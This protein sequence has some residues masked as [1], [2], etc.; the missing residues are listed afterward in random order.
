MILYLDTSALVK[1]YIK[2]AFSD[3]VGKAARVAETCATSR[4]AYVEFYSTLARREREGLDAGTAQGI[5]DAFEA[6]WK[7]VLVVEVNRAIAV[8]AAGL[9]RAHG[10]RG[11]DAVHLASAQGVNEVATD[12]VFAC[13]DAHLNRAAV[14]QTM[15]LL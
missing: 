5:R 15:R 12:M 2:E 9:A 10:L 8:R 6:S 4:I 13:F 1:L 3:E 11:Y 14:A 7:D